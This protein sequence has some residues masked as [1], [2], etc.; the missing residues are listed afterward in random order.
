MRCVAQSK[1]VCRSTTEVVVRTFANTVPGR[2]DARPNSGKWNH[3]TMTLSWTPLISQGRGEILKDFAE[4]PE[5]FDLKC[6][7]G[8]N[9]VQVRS[10]LSLYLQRQPARNKENVTLNRSPTVLALSDRS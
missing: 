7:A 9:I 2:L 8:G 3:H 5:L 10:A 6:G 4:I 1:I